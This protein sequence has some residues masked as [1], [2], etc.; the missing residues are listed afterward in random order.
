MT[1]STM[2][3]TSDA[4]MSPMRKTAL[5]AGLLYIA[6]FVFSIPASWRSTTTW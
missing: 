3:T 6:T 2:T 4:R 5:A 1:T